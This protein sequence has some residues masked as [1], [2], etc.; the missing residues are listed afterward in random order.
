MT[1]P[2]HLLLT[3]A[4]TAFE[5]LDIEEDPTG[6]S[7]SITIHMEI[8]EDDIED[9][10]IA[11]L[12]ALSALSFSDARPAGASEIDFEDD[13]DWTMTDFVSLLRYRRGHLQL[14]ADY[15]RGRRM[16]TNLDLAPDGRL[17]LQVV[18]RG[19]SARR[20]VRLLQGQKPLQL[21]SNHGPFYA[22]SG[23]PLEHLGDWQ[24]V[25]PAKHWKEGRS[26]M[27]LARTWGGAGGFPHVIA[28]ALEREEKL[29][30]LT[31]S[32]GLVEHDVPAPGRGAAS[33]TDIMVF[34]R[35]PLG[36]DVRIAV[37]GKVDE[38][39]DKPIGTWLTGGNSPK[40]PANRR[41]RVEDMLLD[42]CI[43]PAFEGVDALPYQLV[44]RAWSA[45]RSARDGGARRAVFLVHSFLDVEA[46][47]SGWADFVRFARLLFP[48]GPDVEPA[49][50]YLVQR[51]EGVEFWLLWVSDLSVEAS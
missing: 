20:W 26:A 24:A 18:D 25:H 6:P 14:Y 7:G 16:K 50:P 40:S 44:H 10:G 5:V 29:A 35:D 33:K 48:G 9:G 38:G 12:F 11:L 8:D 21:V 42:L 3:A 19:P 45:W 51:L 30:G 47:G 49:R 41:R 32:Q 23:D 34:A 39:F 22:P 43:D 46:K 28:D 4:N 36:N 31:F 2:H 17:S 37:E 15:V 13:D 1:S 27:L